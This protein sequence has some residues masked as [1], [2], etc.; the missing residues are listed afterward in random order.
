MIYMTSRVRRGFPGG[1]RARRKGR[2]TWGVD[3]SLELV[4]V[5]WYNLRL[6]LNGNPI[7]GKPEA[8]QKQSHPEGSIGKQPAW[9]LEK[10]KYLRILT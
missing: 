3:G 2:W 10:V 4:Y 8:S 9:G 1:Q 5:V 6:D 7:P